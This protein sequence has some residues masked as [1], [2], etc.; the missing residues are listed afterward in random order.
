MHV[1]V[2]IGRSLIALLFLAGAAQKAV[3][4]APAMELLTD[5]GVPAGLIWPALAFNFG[6]GLALL[7]GWAVRPVAGLLAIYCGVTS[8]F[9]LIP[10][11]PW[12]M[13]IF[14]KNW[15]IAG[16]CLVLAVHGPGRYVL[17]GHKVE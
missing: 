16:G 7:A 9:H 2:L 6:A 11:D 15:A 12:Q 5:R 1:A 3:D 14:I 4:S 17:G 13:S 10:D 8:I